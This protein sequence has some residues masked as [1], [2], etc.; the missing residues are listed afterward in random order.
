MNKSILKSALTGGFG[1]GLGA[2]GIIGID[3]APVAAD[4]PALVCEQNYGCS[5]ASIQCGTYQYGIACLY[6]GEASGYPTSWYLHINYIVY[7]PGFTVIADGER[8][9]GYS[10]PCDVSGAVAG[11]AFGNYAMCVWTWKSGDNRQ[12]MA[13]AETTVK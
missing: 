6:D 4:N 8:A 13:C 10:R 1:I 12:P 3:A 2:G 5:A 7:G 11:P 9:C